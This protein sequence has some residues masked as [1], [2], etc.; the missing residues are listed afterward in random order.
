MISFQLESINLKHMLKIKTILKTIFWMIIALI[1]GEI[2]GLIGISI[3][4][5]ILT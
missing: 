5:N 4:A 1:F 2:C 3:V